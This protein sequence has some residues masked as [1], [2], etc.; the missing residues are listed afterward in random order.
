MDKQQ[1]QA[2]QQQQIEKLF[3]PDEDRH[4]ANA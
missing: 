2:R 4:A 3:P 1:Q